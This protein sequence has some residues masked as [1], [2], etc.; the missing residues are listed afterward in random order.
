MPDRNRLVAW[1]FAAPLLHTANIAALAEPT[2]F[3]RQCVGPSCWRRGIYA[4][5]IHGFSSI[6]IHGSG[7]VDSGRFVSAEESRRAGEALQAVDS[8]PM[9]ALQS[10][11][12]KRVC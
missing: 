1:C 10:I 6:G 5:G 8:K 11:T 2:V 3:Y 12:A 9:R 4:S 7:R